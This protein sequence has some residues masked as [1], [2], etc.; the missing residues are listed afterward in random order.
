MTRLPE[1]TPNAY[2]GFGYE[3]ASRRAQEV[4]EVAAKTG[5]TMLAADHLA[6]L[7]GIMRRGL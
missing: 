7:A 2:T 5:Q 3:Q 4:C 6:V 1:L